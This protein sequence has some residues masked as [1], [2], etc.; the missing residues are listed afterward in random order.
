MSNI[1]A[2][3][4]Y[5]CCEC[6]TTHDDLCEAE[7]CCAPN[8]STVYACP[9]CGITY[10]DMQHA[11]VCCEEERSLDPLAEMRIPHKT[12]ELYGQQRLAL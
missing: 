8:I 4:K 10:S 3:E 6:D 1:K 7:E 9:T 2:I 12:L 5:V 11:E